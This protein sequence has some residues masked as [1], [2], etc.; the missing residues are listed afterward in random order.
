MLY[1]FLTDLNQSIS[2]TDHDIT[3][4]QPTNF[5]SFN[6]SKIQTFNGMTNECSNSVNEL[7]INFN[8]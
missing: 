8:K 1:Y 7:G 2:V 5:N 3:A 6:N 4:S